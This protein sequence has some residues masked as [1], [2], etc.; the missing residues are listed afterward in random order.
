MSSVV[1]IG[2]DDGR[3][4]MGSTDEDA[5]WLATAVVRGPDGVWRAEVPSADDFR[6]TSNPLSRTQRWL[7]SKRQR[8]LL[9]A[10]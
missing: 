6:T 9:R 10:L 8:K 5:D 7:M 1:S 4:A 2:P 3:V